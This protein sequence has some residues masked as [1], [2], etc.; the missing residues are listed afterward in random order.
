MK[1]S[2]TTA[3]I[4]VLLLIQC[5]KTNLHLV[6]VPTL[7]TICCI[8]CS[9]DIVNNSTS[10]LRKA[11]NQHTHRQSTIRSQF[12]VNVHFFIS[13]EFQQLTVVLHTAH[14]SQLVGTTIIGLFCACAERQTITESKQKLLQFSNHSVDNAAGIELCSNAP[15]FKYYRTTDNKNVSVRS[16]QDIIYRFIYYIG[17]CITCGNLKCA[18]LLDFENCQSVS[19]IIVLPHFSTW[20]IS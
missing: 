18:I 1:L 9:D 4:V 16:R 13:Y 3:L 20:Q 7:H 8:R 12:L 15:I 6:Q 14:T 11:S 2:I 19:S 17:K 5:G 10:Q